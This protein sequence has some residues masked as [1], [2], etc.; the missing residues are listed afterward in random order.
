MHVIKI[1]DDKLLKQK[2]EKIPSDTFN[3]IISKTASK[4]KAYLYRHLKYELDEYHRL[5][6]IDE[7][8]NTGK[9]FFEK[10]SKKLHERFDMNK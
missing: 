10:E 2:L 1:M 4:R 7:I 3:D 9:T 6:G 8:L 5:D